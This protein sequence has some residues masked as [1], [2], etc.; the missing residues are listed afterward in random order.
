MEDGGWRV[1]DG[2]WRMED[3]GWRVEDGGWRMEDGEWRMED[4]GWR[5]E[6]GG[7]RVEGGGWRMDAGPSEMPVVANAVIAHKLSA[8]SVVKRN[9]HNCKNAARA[10][11]VRYARIRRSSQARCP[12]REQ[13]VASL[14]N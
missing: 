13:K 4:G 2:G 7:W 11:S 6:D 5:V 9:A 14:G 10:P 12:R 8:S 3:G 1:E